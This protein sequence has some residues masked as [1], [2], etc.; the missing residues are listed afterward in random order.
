MRWTRL[1][2][3]SFPHLLITVSLASA[4]SPL[5]SKNGWLTLNKGFIGFLLACASRGCE[6]IYCFCLSWLAV[7]FLLFVLS[8]LFCKRVCVF[9]FV[10]VR[11]YMC[12]LM[13]VYVCMCVFV[14][15]FVCVRVCICVRIS[16][17]VAEYVHI[18]FIYQYKILF[19][20]FFARPW[21][22]RTNLFF[23]KVLCLA[24]LK[25]C[26]YMFGQP[27]TLSICSIYPFLPALLVGF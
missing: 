6:Y 9:V 16:V 21:S 5:P 2:I 23:L 26:P 19:F 12:I 15:A 17:S 3:Y 7:A 27:F 18:Y 4:H 24:E 11:M 10:F 1:W 22:L 14:C 13:R 20:F 25:S 8:L